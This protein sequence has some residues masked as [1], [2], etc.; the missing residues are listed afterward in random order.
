MRECNLLIAGDTSLEVG[1]DNVKANL[2]VAFEPPTTFKTYVQYKVM[3]C[4]LFRP[5]DVRTFRDSAAM[6]R[7]AALLA[8]C[9]SAKWVDTMQRPLSLFWPSVMRQL[10]RAIHLSLLFFNYCQFQVY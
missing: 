2:V 4:F 6:S 10:P 7:L 8:R 1:V 9:A 5:L 3:M